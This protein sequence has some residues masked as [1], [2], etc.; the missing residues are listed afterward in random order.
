MTPEDKTI[1]QN[2]YTSQKDLHIRL[3]APHGEMGDRMRGFCNQLKAALPTLTIKKESDETGFSPPV[4]IVGIH[5]NIAIKAVPSGKLL[6][7]LLT[8][9]ETS[10]EVPPDMGNDV[11]GQL[12]QIDLPVAL[13]LYI[14]PHCPHCP[15]TLEKLLPLAAANRHLRLTIIDAQQFQ[16]AAQRD[17][18]RSVPT[19]ILDDQFRWSG[20]MDLQEILTICIQ[21]DPAQL[22]AASLRQLI[23]DGQAQRV[24][25][26]MVAADTIFPALVELIT[27]ERW[28]VRLG[29]M[30][31]A[32]YLADEAAPLAL[33]LATR[34]W[35]RFADLTDPIKGDVLQV[36]GQANCDTAR[37]YL[38]SVLSGPFD[39]SV[40]EAAADALKNM[41]SP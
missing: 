36:I 40:K 10:G 1:I 35:D 33:N 25:Q 8:A 39:E 31:T 18:I 27:H 15:G 41:P 13:T 26:M 34:L 16:H 6:R 28:S 22:S 19:L 17:Q 32:E 9:I 7:P 11:N 21:R 5:N 37:G 38:D 29:A 14:A 3:A 4:I 24:A 30:V 12:Q 20:P 23:E 2:W